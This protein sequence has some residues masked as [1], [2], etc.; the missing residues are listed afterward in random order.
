MGIKIIREE[1][2]KEPKKPK[3]QTAFSKKLV[4]LF[5]VSSQ[6]VTLGVLALCWLC[7]VYNYQGTLPFLS[8]L[9]GL[10]EISLGYVCSKY[11][12]KSTSENTKGGIVYDLAM[13][14]SNQCNQCNPD[15]QYNPNLTDNQYEQ[16]NT[17]EQGGTDHE[18]Y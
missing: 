2:P 18:V 8:A 9:I 5:M 6:V 7:I 17:Y 15:N 10:Q 16:N 3:K 14:Q 4:L 13:T 11:M 12:T 1:K